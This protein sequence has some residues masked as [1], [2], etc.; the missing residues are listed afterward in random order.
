[1]TN[2]ATDDVTLTNIL[3]LTHAFNGHFNCFE[4]RGSKPEPTKS[5]QVRKIKKPADSIYRLV[6]MSKRLLNQET[7]FLRRMRMVL[8][9]NGRSNKAPATTVLGSGTAVV[10]AENVHPSLSS[11]GS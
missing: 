8:T 3:Q 7:L 6:A 11:E 9:P 1:M 5:K 10:E 4:T 2:V